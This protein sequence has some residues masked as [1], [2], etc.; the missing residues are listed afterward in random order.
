MR[1]QISAACGLILC[2]VIAGPAAA[3]EPGAPEQLITR[4]DAVGVEVQK[5][6]A[7]SFRAGSES[8]YEK[9]EHGA[10]VEYY[11]EH[12]DTP[13]WVDADGLTDRARAV[14]R[15]LARAADYGLNSKDYA[16]PKLEAAKGGE[17]PSSVKLAEAEVMLSHAVLAYV[18]D[19]RGGRMVP[20]SISRNLDPTLHLPDPL[21]VMEKIAERDEPASY[22]VDFHPK[23]PQFEALRKVLLQIRGGVE[24]KKVVIPKGPLIRPGDSHKQVALLRKRLKAPAAQ[25]DDGKKAAANRYGSEL[26]KAVKAF[27]KSRGLN[28]EGIVGPATRRALNARPRHSGRTILANMERWRWLPDDTV[29]RLN[30]QVNVPE[31]TMRVFEGLKPIHTERVVVGKTK[32]AT[33]IFSDQMETI[34]F[35]PYWNVPNSIKVK[36]ILPNLR[37]NVLGGGWFGGYSRGDARFLA[38]NELYVK[39]RGRPVDPSSVNWSS[40]DIK[41]YHFYQKPGGG[42]VL[43]VVKFMFPNKHA[44]YMHDTPTKHLFAKP[45]RA[46]SHGCMR[47]RNPQRLAELLLA[48]DSGWSKGRVSKAVQSKVHRPVK[49]QKPIPVHVTYF[50]ARVSEKGKVRYFG[51]LYGHDARMAKALKF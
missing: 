5:R 46:Y 39:Y 2:A 32:N 7:A 45:V 43:G 19:A 14:M 51:D 48:K 15:E 26:V 42:N 18:R 12:A 16:L 21:E 22:L 24:E 6:L 50:T 30:V 25:S 13:V 10:L 40:V 23:H 28:A 17:K 31:F 20:G 41:R 9:I 27:Q 8:H 34:V 49:L 11:A 44:V 47:V 38:R 36:E 4:L 29:D 35:H 1:L 3:A 37:R 33:P